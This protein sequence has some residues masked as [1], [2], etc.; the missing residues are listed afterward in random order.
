V[1]AAAGLDL[2]AQQRRREVAGGV[3]RLR[4][5]PPDDI[6]P[7]VETNQQ[8]FRRML[9]LT[10]RPPALLG[11][12]PGEVSGAL[13]MAGLTADADLCPGTGEAVIHRVVILAHAGRVA[14]GAH[15]IP[16]LVQLGPMQD[17]VVLDLLVR[18]EMEPALA[19]LLL[20]AVIPGDRQGLQPAVRKFDEILLQRLDAEGVFYLERGELAV[21]VVGLDEEFPGLAEEAGM[22]AVMV[23][24]RVAE[25]AEHRLVGRMLHGELV[26]R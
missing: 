1:T 13:A 9:T 15:E 5:A 20:G 21:R 4:V 2:L 22:H 19:A 25:I 14:L 3:P 24:V 6:A 18:I 26:L 12:R 17:V 8:T 23:K 16:V 10:E 11:A 7:L